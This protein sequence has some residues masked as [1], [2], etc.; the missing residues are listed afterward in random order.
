MAKHNIHI[1]KG[2]LL[3][4]PSRYH[5]AKRGGNKG[6]RDA[7]EQNRYNNEYL[8]SK[9]YIKQSNNK[10]N[11][12]IM[13]T[14]NL[15]ESSLGSAV[16]AGVRAG[17][18]TNFCAS[19]VRSLAG[20]CS[21]GVGRLT[22]AALVGAWMRDTANCGYTLNESEGR[23]LYAANPADPRVRRVGVD[24]HWSFF[25]APA[26]KHEGETDSSRESDSITVTVSGWLRSWSAWYDSVIRYG[27]YGIGGVPSGSC[28]STDLLNRCKDLW[29]FRGVG[30]R[31]AATSEEKRQKKVAKAVEGLD[32][33]S[34]LAA[35]RASGVDLSALAA[36][37]GGAPAANQ[38]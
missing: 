31:T 8:L 3:S 37:A 28:V 5:K 2:A 24:G 38:D 12:K 15:L 27:H 17:M 34:L 16:L 22:Y 35:L 23:K 19:L 21:C 7:L 9:I 14:K 36:A 13:A 29:S 18:Y 11:N 26:A 4:S 25:V 33:A 1:F 32:A 20:S 10:L 6:L 30:G